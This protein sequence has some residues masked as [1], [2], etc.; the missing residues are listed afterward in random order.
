MINI[1]LF[2]WQLPQNIL[3]FLYK[4][5]FFSKSENFRDCTVIKKS[6]AGSVSLGNYLFIYK[7]TANYDKTLLHEYGHH[8]QSLY[9][10]PLYLLII[11]IPSIC[12]A[13]LRRQGFFKNKS[14]YSFYPEK[15]ADKLGG[16][17][18]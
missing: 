14:Y 12:W 18:R 5:L 16:V 8:K 10:G 17:V 9:L 6:S 4:K 11:G 1:I 3:G 15:W 13:G 7:Y 2:I